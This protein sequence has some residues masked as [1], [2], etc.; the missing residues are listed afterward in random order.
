MP[1]DAEQEPRPFSARFTLRANFRQAD[2]VARH[3]SLDGDPNNQEWH[4]IDSERQQCIHDAGPTNAYCRCISCPGSPANGSTPS[5]SKT[6][7]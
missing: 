6:E 2:G 4:Q 3:P 5:P 1:P 7:R